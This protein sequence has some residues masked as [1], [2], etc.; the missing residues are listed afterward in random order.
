MCRIKTHFSK[1][2]LEKRHNPRS[3]PTL[4]DPSSKYMVPKRKMLI[5]LVLAQESKIYITLLEKMHT[6]LVLIG[7]KCQYTELLAW[8]TSHIFSALQPKVTLRNEKIQQCLQKRHYS[9]IHHCARLESFLESCLKME[10]PPSLAKKC[11]Y[12]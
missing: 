7:A 12:I 1:I 11:D 2:L 10:M 9:P 3:P 8:K 4:F 5:Y 6:Y